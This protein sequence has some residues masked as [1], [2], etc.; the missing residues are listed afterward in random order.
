MKN[1]NSFS[2]L[3]IQEDGQSDHEIEI[4][5]GV[6]ERLLKKYKP[7]EITVKTRHICIIND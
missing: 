1:I 6:T 2:S 7:F 4:N 3:S 5:L